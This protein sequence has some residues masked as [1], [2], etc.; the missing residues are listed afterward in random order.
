MYSYVIQFNLGQRGDEAQE[1]L[2]DAVRV[3]PRLWGEIPGVTGTLLLSSA[4]AL[5]GEFEYQWRVDIEGLA[6]LSR[7]D[8]AI[9]SGDG[10]WR[11]A[12]KEWFRAR[13]AA[14]AQVSGHVGGN[15]EYSRGQKGKD[16][17]IHYVF[18]SPSGES[19]RSADRLEALGSVSGVIS[20]QALSPVIGSFDSPE[21]TWVRLESL[22]SLDAVAEVDLGAGHGRLFG[23]IREVDGSLFVGA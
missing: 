23:E 2:A 11:K 15:E 10:G 18:H 19:G 14:R 9:R 6:T 20:A 16:G 21:Q 17:A 3:W 22:E 13:T 7:I 1:Y 12:S 8:D 5:G 4:L